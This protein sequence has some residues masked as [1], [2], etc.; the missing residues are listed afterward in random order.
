MAAG[1]SSGDGTGHA[2]DQYSSSTAMA[3]LTAMDRPMTSQTSKTTSFKLNL[4]KKVL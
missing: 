2:R 1:M 3:R 4:T